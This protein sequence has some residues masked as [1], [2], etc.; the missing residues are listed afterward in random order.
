MGKK[1]FNIAVL[2]SG[3][4]SDLQAI[5]D[6]IKSRKM[7][8]VKLVAVVSD[9][10]DSY[11]LE[12]AKEQGFDTFFV[13]PREKNRA[14]YGDELIHLLQEK[15]VDLVCLAGFMRIL[16]PNVIEAFKWQMINVHPSLLPKYGGKGMHGNHVH[17]AVL[18]AR[19]SVSG[20]TIH[21]VD[22]GCDTG[23]II[24]Q[25]EVDIEEGENPLTLRGKIVALEK[26]WY[27]EVIRW[28]QNGKV[29]VGEDD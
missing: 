8:G 23:P 10:E 17:E 11:A 21:F 26:K 14:E 22:E 16:A 6:Q 7:P 18:A 2:S 3:N 27:P 15:Q 4:G 13:D 25:A 1:S 12:R 20:M 9:V 5:I 28:I 29:V 24:H 19:E